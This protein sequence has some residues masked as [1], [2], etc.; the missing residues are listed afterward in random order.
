MQCE[1]CCE[2]STPLLFAG[3]YIVV[4]INHRTVI[5]ATLVHY[6]VVPLPFVSHACV[7]LHK[8][9]QVPTMFIQWL[10]RCGAMQN[11]L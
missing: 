2:Y 9:P 6:T 7:L 10:P 11:V 4:V 3:L 1:C 8:R 5:V